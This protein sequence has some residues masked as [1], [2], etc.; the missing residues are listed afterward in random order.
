MDVQGLRNQEILNKEIQ[1]FINPSTFP[2]MHPCFHGFRHPSTHPT[3]YLLNKDP[4]WGTWVAQSVKLK[5]VKGPALDFSSAGST[6]PTWDSLSPSL[7]PPLLT[8]M[9]THILSLS[10]I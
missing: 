4:L 10:Q 3:I 6:E 9:L 2:P 8:H 7:C 1:E 5:Q